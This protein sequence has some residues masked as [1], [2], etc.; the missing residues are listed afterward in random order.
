MA[1]QVFANSMEISCKSASG[2]SVAAFPDVCFTPPQAPPTPMGVPIPYP[3][4]GLAKDT[5]RGTRS[6]KITR[7][8]VMRKNK[9]FFKT[10]Y[11]DEPGCAPKKGILTGKIK[12][13]VYFTSWS[14]NVK[15]EGLNVV[16]HMDLTTHNHG[17]MPGN[18]PPWPYMDEMAM[19]VMNCDE[20]LE[21][22]PVKN[23]SEQQKR[24]Q[25]IKQET[26]VEYQSHHV[27][28]NSHFC[29][30]RGTTLKEICP[31]YDEA[32]APCIAL[33]DG[34]DPSTGHGRVSQMQ[35]ADAKR[36]RDAYK[37]KQT[38]PTYQDARA[39]AK[40][41]LIEPEP[42]PGLS[43]NDAECV[44]REVDKQ[45]HQMCKSGMQK[46]KQ[47][48]LRA[49]GTRGTALPQKVVA[50]KAQKSKLF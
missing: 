33:E 3:N 45:F 15:V 18:T 14:M 49:P 26:G 37:D 24:C 25:A 4:T 21:R 23:H 36:Y 41:Q 12:G 8:E 29:Y 20:A 28:Q 22:T 44:L 10:S 47:F 5:S 7:K 6:V 27:I 17:S 42:G 50:K 34:T 2:K 39:D 16:R 38:S 30:P 32:L 13:K 1:N 46:P 43:E 40:R 31:G 35:K 11:G 48:E 19:A 9:S